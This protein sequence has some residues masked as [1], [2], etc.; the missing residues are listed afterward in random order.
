[1]ELKEGAFETKMVPATCPNYAF[2]FLVSQKD[3]QWPFWPL[4]PSQLPANTV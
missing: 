2:V 4:F 1:M 3:A